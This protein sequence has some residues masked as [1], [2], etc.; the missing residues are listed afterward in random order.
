M[1]RGDSPPL[2]FPFLNLFSWFLLS[3]LLDREEYIEQA[4][5]FR[6]LQERMQQ[7][8]ST[9]DLLVAI[10]QEILATTKLPMALEF[11]SQELRLTGGFAPA[12]TKLS[13][14]FTP[15]Q[16]YLVAEAEREGGRF[17]FR[18][19]MEILRRDAEYRSEKPTPQGAFLFQ[20]EVL[21]RNRLSYFKGLR[22][23]GQ[24][25]IYDDDWRE[26]IDMVHR[27]IGLV[28]FAD[29]IYVRSEYYVQRQGDPGKPTLFGEK[30]GRIALANRQKDPLYLFSAL[31]RQLGY[32]SVP[33]P[34]K[35]S[36]TLYQIP[37]LKRQ[38]ERLE[39]RLKLLEEEQRGGINIAK[40][41]VKEEG[42]S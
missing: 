30:E 4:Y 10:R 12:M 34:K 23:A 3:M 39:S 6:T 28:D 19:A 11:M 38:V 15:L 9:Q 27:Q 14:Y 42:K 5:F 25:P 22:A 17:D 29:M 33:R 8:M 36:E 21:S 16:A 7:A 1:A 37:A 35:L 40:Y 32:P 41:Y 24:D 20:F 18:I 2:F 26:W 31:Q 13:H